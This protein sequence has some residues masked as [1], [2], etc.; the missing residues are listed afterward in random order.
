MN[1]HLP[2]PASISWFTLV[3]IAAALVHYA[4][5]VSL[6]AWQLTPSWA[7]VCGFALAFPVSYIGHRRW[8]F[9]QQAASHGQA[10]PR[11]LAV[12]I[13]GFAANQL[14]LISLLHGYSWLPFWLVLGLVMVVIAVSTYVLSRYWAF[15]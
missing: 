7:N 6:E 8:S 11:F 10:L 15:K 1:D 2:T 3:G 14:L 13:A 12:A 4:V 9:A 5:A